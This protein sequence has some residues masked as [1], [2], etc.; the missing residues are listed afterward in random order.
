ML[1]LQFPAPIQFKETT[2]RYGKVDAILMN[3][4]SD[5][6]LLGGDIPLKTVTKNVILNGGVRIFSGSLR[7]SFVR[8]MLR[9]AIMHLLQVGTIMNLG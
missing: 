8:P 7:I 9:D 6:V 1:N 4:K 2:L 5:L 3:K